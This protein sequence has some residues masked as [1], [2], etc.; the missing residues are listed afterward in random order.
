MTTTSS[1]PLDVAL[2][3]HE[4]GEGM[5]TRPMRSLGR[6]LVWVADVVRQVGGALNGGRGA[7]KYAPKL[8]EQRRDY[9]P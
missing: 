1:D 3:V 6:F 4:Y 9:R 2:A 5:L 7:D 8:Y